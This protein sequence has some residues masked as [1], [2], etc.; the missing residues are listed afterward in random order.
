[1]KTAIRGR[2]LALLLYRTTR[3]FHLRYCTCCVKASQNAL[4][5]GVY[6]LQCFIFIVLLSSC[7]NRAASEDNALSLDRA[8]DS[9]LEN[10][11]EDMADNPSENDAMEITWDNFYL[12]RL[13]T[14]NEK[15]ASF[16]SERFGVS[17][18]A[19]MTYDWNIVTQQLQLRNLPDIFWAF[20]NHIETLKN[21]GLVRTIPWEMIKRH[22]PRYAALLNK[23]EHLATEYGVNKDE[24]YLLLGLEETEDML[25]TFSVYRLDWL[26]E[27]GVEPHG[28]VI[29]IADRVYFTDTPFTYNEF[30]YIIENFS[31][32][33]SDRYGL[34]S[35]ALLSSGHKLD[36]LMG[37]WG[38]NWTN[39][40]EDGKA[41]L[42]A[43][44]ENFKDFLYFVDSLI[45]KGVIFT[46]KSA[47]SDYYNDRIG[48]WNADIRQIIGTQPGASSGYSD[49]I[50]RIL[51]NNISVKHLYAPP[52]LGPN[53]RSGVDF[54][55]AG[56]VK[57]NRRFM[58][59]A[60]V[61]D[62]KLA[63]IL[64]IFDGVSFEAELY[65]AAMFGIEGE[66]F[67]WLGE[68][69]NSPV[70]KET[71]PVNDDRQAYTTY[72][73]D[74]LA[75]KNL[76]FLSSEPLQTVYHYATSAEAL[77][78]NL[79]PYKS[80]PYGE[81]AAEEAALSQIYEHT[82]YELMQTYFD[83]IKSGNKR[84][85]ET[86]EDYMNELKN[87][88]LDAYNELVNKYPITNRPINRPIG[89]K[90]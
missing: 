51:P 57:V 58:I 71:E 39:I 18:R 80:D 35:Y 85:G 53:G 20:D 16:L 67:H 72:M 30:L 73:M 33:E 62:A 34:A 43:G 23:Y 42:S 28:N 90:K 48:W 1:M 84:V 44:S 69:Y 68:P 19:N 89:Y 52:E 32:P 77:A 56:S 9:P 22:A 59:N 7:G 46:D 65:V 8:T 47:Y 70:V 3:I 54:K 45:E 2:Y 49:Y 78:S 75:G 6:F 24:I 76:Y 74:G 81:L 37:M 41:V 4:R 36:T 29:E 25:N 55:D 79:P 64:E 15:I 38:V 14:G 5:V 87:N 82:P 61:S 21:N 17:I 10:S 27:I 83:D 40:Q 50:T 86:W 63:K 31:K 60:G 88:G 13:L 66:D 12:N 26:E 11:R